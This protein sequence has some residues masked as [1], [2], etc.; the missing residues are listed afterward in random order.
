MLRQW[1]VGSFSLFR[2]AE[3]LKAGQ[4]TSTV[5]PMALSNY[6]LAFMHL[7]EF[8]I[9]HKNFNDALNAVQDPIEKATVLN[10][11]GLAFFKGQTISKS[12]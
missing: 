8:Q 4:L 3:D 7:G 2:A 10:N 6:G 5:N 12:N 1:E 11:K 9:A